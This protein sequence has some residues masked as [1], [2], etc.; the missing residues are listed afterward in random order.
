[1]AIVVLTGPAASGKNTVS[2]I[3]AKKRNR[4]AVI[5]VDLVR[6]M[7]LQRHKAPWDGEEGKEQQRLGVENSA[8]LAQNFARNDIDAILLDVVVDETA[9]L[10]KK[11]LPQAKI[12]LLMPSY[13][14]ALKR[15]SQRPPTITEEEFKML[16]AWQEKLTIYDKKI[17]NT[18]L[19]VEKTASEINSLL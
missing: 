17:D 10:Y 19:S 8:G 14:E 18:T 6:W 7:Y 15:F 12:I 9:K 5:D 1:M 11:Y 13:E 16:Y 2:H 3:L 4:C